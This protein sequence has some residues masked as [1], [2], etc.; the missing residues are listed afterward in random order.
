[1]TLRRSRLRGSAFE[2]LINKSNDIYL[3][4]SEALVQ[5]ISTPIKP[6]ALGKG[7]MITCAFFEKKS[8]VDYLGVSKNKM[9]CFDAKET[10]QKSLPIKNIHNHQIEFMGEFE[11]H[12]GVSFLLVNFTFNKTF[13][14]LP[15]SDLY[16]SYKNIEFKKSISY[17][18]FKHEIIIIDEDFLDYLSKAKELLYI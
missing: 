18:D 1:M 4:S 10:S 13:F 17:K 8:T 11:K 14:Y 16:K 2:E 9:F 7:G 15:F 5:K 3:N 6:I 12:G